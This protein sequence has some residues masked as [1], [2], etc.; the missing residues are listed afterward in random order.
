MSPQLVHGWSSWTC[1]ESRLLKEIAI[2]LSKCV[3][4]HVQRHLLLGP[5]ILEKK[6]APSFLM[7]TVT[8]SYDFC[9]FWLDR[10]GEYLGTHKA[11]SSWTCPGAHLLKEIAIFLSKLILSMST[12]CLAGHAQGPIYLMKLQFSQVNG[13]PACPC[14]PSCLDWPCPQPRR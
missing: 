9:Y 12:A 2:S 3:S 4:G 6:L 11:R 10:V 7:K 8:F 1:P 5:E 14:L 13:S